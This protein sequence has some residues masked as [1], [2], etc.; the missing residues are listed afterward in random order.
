MRA[1]FKYT[2][3]TELAVR[4]TAFAVIFVMDAV[5]IALG[6]LGLLPIAAMV[7]AMSL[8]GVAITVMLV[9]NIVGDVAIIRRMISVP[10]AYLYAL[11]PSPRWKIILASA[12]VTA[13]L[14]IVTMAVVIM[15][16]K[17]LTLIVE[18][19]KIW[20]YVKDYVSADNSAFLYR[21]WF[22]ALLA[23]GYLLLLMVILFCITV[24]KSVLFRVPASG[25]LAFLLACVCIYVI[26]LLQLA[27]TPFGD[28]NRYGLVIILNLKENALPFYVL[29]TLL[30][31]SAFFAVTSK[32]ME[33]KVNL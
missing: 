22:L 2:F 23:A 18:G 8:G 10:E 17:W 7:I 16:E 26:T 5:F 21:L 15:A 6:S 14:D 27:L 12:S 11:T 3:K 9:F 29:L 28:L 25:F 20:R 13:I 32:L 24:Y 19:E 4:G 1:H 31:A 33:K 30:E